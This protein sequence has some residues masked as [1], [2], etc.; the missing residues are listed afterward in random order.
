MPLEALL[1]PPA[2][3]VAA[4]GAGLVLF[5][6]LLVPVLALQGGSRAQL[7]ARL[8]EL[9]RSGAAQKSRREDAGK[10][11]NRLTHGR[12][13]E[14][15]D[16]SARKRRRVALR[17]QIEQAGLGWSVGRF[18]LV[19][20]VSG[21]AALLVYLF[22]G[23]P[24]WGAVFAP[25]AGALLLP[26][27][28]L[29]RLAT[30]R[31]RKFTGQLA[32]AID[33]IVRGIRSGL[34]VGECLDIIARESPEPIGGEFKLVVEGQRVGLTLREIMEKAVTRM[35]T[36]DMR[37]FAV[38]LILQQKTGGNLA[39]ALANLS[40]ILRARK[41]MAEK[42]RAMSSEAR[43]TASIIGSLP[44]ILGG[45]IY[46][47]NPGYIGVLFTDPT[48]RIMVVGGGVWMGIGIFVM[49]QMVSFKV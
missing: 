4:L 20:A 30:G 3:Y 17:S 44:F 25:V 29:R 14:L 21:A 23:M 8:A 34:P 2:V 32:D 47:I 10:G 31:Q 7:R 40:G 48:G 22:G 15:G 39:E 36:A 43:M 12:V 18:Y 9:G 49:K 16:E 13:K 37:F 28:F 26:R 33:V 1:A 35:P 19:S 41:K 38:V 46:L 27:L 42:V 45:L 6:L 5:L 11:G 24:L